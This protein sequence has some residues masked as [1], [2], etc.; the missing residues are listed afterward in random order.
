MTK[1]EVELDAAQIAGLEW[2]LALNNAA[3][4]ENNKRQ[5]VEDQGLPEPRAVT[6]QVSLTEFIQQMVADQA[7]RYAKQQQQDDRQ[8]LA[9]KI[10]TVD[11]ATLTKVKALL[12]Q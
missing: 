12:P 1:Y 6:P 9:D 2:R 10:A 7:D 4:D 8:K 3:I 11:E 5:A